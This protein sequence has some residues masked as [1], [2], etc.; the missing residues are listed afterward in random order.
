[1]EPNTG[2]PTGLG[3]EKPSKKSQKKHN[4]RASKSKRSYKHKHRKAITN[5]SVAKQLKTSIRKRETELRALKK[6]LKAI[7]KLG[8]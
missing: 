6:A 7:E 1:M 3:T 2:S 5:V 4:K 8:R